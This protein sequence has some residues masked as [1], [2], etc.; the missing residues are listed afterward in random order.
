MIHRVRSTEVFEA[1]QWTG[2]NLKEIAD[3]VGGRPAYL[4]R[5]RNDECVI[6]GRRDQC[7]LYILLGKWIVKDKD[8]R[9]D[10]Y[11]NDRFVREFERIA[12]NPAASPVTPEPP[13]APRPPGTIYTAVD[14][15]TMKVGEDGIARPE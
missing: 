10:T 3:W 15:E 11:T 2:D 1:V 9:L 13:H 8:R 14:G 5:G 4:S 12:P 7:A 6:P